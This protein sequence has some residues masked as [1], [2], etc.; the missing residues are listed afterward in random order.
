MDIAGMFNFIEEYEYKCESQRKP[1]Q[2]LE[3]PFSFT[4]DT[5]QLCYEAACFSQVFDN[6]N[7]TGAL[8]FRDLPSTRTITT[9]VS[10][11][12]TSRP[13]RKFMRWH[14]RR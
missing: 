1:L 13:V 14:A 5:Y 11:E 8:T 7:S 6:L 10:W 12:S 2:A 9:L 4:L 3:P